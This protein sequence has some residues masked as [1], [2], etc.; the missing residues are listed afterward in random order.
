[1]CVVTIVVFVCDRC[2]YVLGN[3]Y[4]V[5]KCQTAQANKI[6]VCPD[7]PITHEQREVSWLGC[8]ECMEDYHQWQTAKSQGN[9]Y[10]PDPPFP[11]VGA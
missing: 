6:N 4:V 7:S 8:E 2:Y 3:D 10:S 5:N 11:D 1:M 9:D